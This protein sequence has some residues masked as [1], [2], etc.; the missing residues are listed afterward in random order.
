MENLNLDFSR[1]WAMNQPQLA[2]LMAQTTRAQMEMPE[3]PSPGPRVTDAPGGTR[4]IQIEGALFRRDNWLTMCGWGT[5]YDWIYDQVALAVNDVMVK[6]IL[7]M[8]NS[9]GGECDGCFE[10]ADW[11]REQ[12]D[13]K[14]I[15]AY[16]QSLAASAAYE[17]A[18][19]TKKITVGPVGYVGSVGVIACVNDYRRFMT[20]LGIDEYVFVSSVSP[21]KN[22]DPATDPGK[23]QIQ[24]MV[25]EMGNIFVDSVAKLRHNPVEHVVQNFG[26]G[27]ILIASKALEVGMCDQIGNLQ[28]AI[29]GLRG[30]GMSHASTVASTTTTTTETV[31]DDEEQMQEGAP[32]EEVP[33]EEEPKE[34]AQAPETDKAEAFAA[35]NPVLAASLMSRGAAAERKRI[36]EID[37]VAALYP[38]HKELAEKA[39]FKTS[40]SAGDFAIACVKASKGAADAHIAKLDQDATEV[41]RL[42]GSTQSAN[43]EQEI[44]KRAA[45]GAKALDVHSR[46]K[47]AR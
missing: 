26:Q 3:T 23:A 33:V 13:K 2:R 14:P 15:H 18:C 9:P 20:E 11:I 38:Y 41:P 36:Q 6:D 12:S 8:I 32:E 21:K 39:K 34:D 42:Q 4:I 44:N 16:V 5:S 7:F 37:E 30:D 43:K 29:E 10:L 24:G 25:D 45:D 22:P 17:I 35:K 27:A 47:G 31:T 1:P 28:A 40:M 19:S 46:I